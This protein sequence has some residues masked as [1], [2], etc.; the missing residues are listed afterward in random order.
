PLARHLKTL[1]LATAV[2]GTAVV[3]GVHA[4]ADHL[5]YGPFG[6]H[7]PTS[8]YYLTPHPG[9][10]CLPKF[11]MWAQALLAFDVAFLALLSLLQAVRASHDEVAS[12]AAEA[13]AQVTA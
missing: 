5:C 4:A 2:I 1:A 13:T 3:L 9:G 11:G 7:S 6:H 12:E 8:R 10:S